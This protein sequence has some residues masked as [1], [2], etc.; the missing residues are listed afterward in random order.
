MRSASVAKHLQEQNLTVTTLPGGY[1]TFRRW[2]LEQ[3]EVPRR[4]ITL[5]GFTGSG[6]TA[7]LHALRVLGEQI[8]DLEALAGHRGS[9]F[10]MIGLP[11]QPTTEHFENKVACALQACDP[12]KPVWIEDESRMIGR[13]KIPDALWKQIQQAPLI[14]IEPPLEE[15]IARLL[16]DYGNASL[17]E[18]GSATLRISRRLGGALAKEIAL[19]ISQGDLEA[20]AGMLLKHYD[21]AYAHS[22]EKKKRP[23]S[24]LARVGLAPAAWASL[25][26]KCSQ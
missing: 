18:L 19:K 24:R 25:L 26:Q 20:A 5:G 12:E 15:R 3:F 7:I 23:S 14:C 10:G 11:P 16:Q 17:D 1:K 8:L 21:A 2:V 4:W 9:S 6:K 13:C 22:L